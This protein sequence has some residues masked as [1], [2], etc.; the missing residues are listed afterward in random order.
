MPRAVQRGRDV[1]S[2]RPAFSATV[3]NRP[4]EQRSAR[5]GESR[6]PPPGAPASRSSVPPSPAR[7]R[8]PG[9]PSVG[10]R[11]VPRTWFRSNNPALHRA[12][13]TT[14]G[15]ALSNARAALGSFALMDPISRSGV[16]DRGIRPRRC[17]SMDGLVRQF[18]TLHPPAGA[19]RH[20]GGAGRRCRFEGRATRMR[21]S[22]QG[23]ISL[24]LTL[25][26]RLG[27][28]AD[29]SHRE[30]D[31][32]LGDVGGGV[33]D[34][35]QVAG[36]REQPCSSRCLRASPRPRPRFATMLFTSGLAPGGRGSFPSSREAGV[37]A[38][39]SSPSVDESE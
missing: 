38:R 16:N 19:P 32:V 27:V 36:S 8:R 15:G 14:P 1:T 39:C 13:R 3:K 26:D 10:V 5:Q 6:D 23:G 24:R 25:V 2:R 18:R 4:S 34:P 30:V 31:H 22:A 17:E 20:I 11:P 12:T 9:R 29:D 21:Q 28:V 35:L 7:V 37:R 33:G